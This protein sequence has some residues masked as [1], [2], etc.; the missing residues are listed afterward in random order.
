MRAD[1]WKGSE[2]AGSSSCARDLD[3]SNRLLHHFF[4]NEIHRVPLDLNLRTSTPLS[5]S[6]SVSLLSFLASFLAQRKPINRRTPSLRLMGR[7]ELCSLFVEHPHS[8]GE[9]RFIVNKHTGWSI[10]HVGSC[11]LQGPQ[12]SAS[13]RRRRRFRCLQI[14]G[15]SFPATLF[16]SQSN[17][18]HL[19]TSVQI[20]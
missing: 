15:S 20:C 4:C 12:Q 2:F 3:D 7:Q 8:G 17:L 19:S 11:V 10:E 13:A 1:L 6:G 14:S 9:N 5:S 18:S 16:P